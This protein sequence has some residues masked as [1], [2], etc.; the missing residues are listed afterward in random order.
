MVTVHKKI[1]L[2]T[3]TLLF[4][5]G[6]AVRYIV[7]LK[8]LLQACISFYCKKKFVVRGILDQAVYNLQMLCVFNIK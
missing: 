4:Y 7:L 1:N 6:S 8:P 3:L 5:A 2:C